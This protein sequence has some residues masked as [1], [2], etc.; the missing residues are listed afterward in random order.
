LLIKHGDK[1]KCTKAQRIRWIGHILR[2]DKESTVERKTIWRPIVVRII[3]R[4]SLRLE[5]DVRADLGKMQ[6]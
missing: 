5:N 1:I 2:M 3:G 4:P 6:I